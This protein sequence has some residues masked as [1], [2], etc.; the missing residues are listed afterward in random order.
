MD[1]TWPLGWESIRVLN[2]EGFLGL[3]CDNKIGLRMAYRVSVLVAMFSRKGLPNLPMLG[4]DDQVLT[5]Y[6][7][8]SA[9]AYT[10]R[11]KEVSCWWRSLLFDKKQ[12]TKEY[13]RNN[14]SYGD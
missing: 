3:D 10:W 12:A 4:V 9:Y 14:E 2:T 7:L 5:Q 8:G 6:K 11:V 13:Y 1:C